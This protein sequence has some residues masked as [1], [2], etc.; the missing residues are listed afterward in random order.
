MEG[1]ERLRLQNRVRRAD[2]A[3]RPSLVKK[4]SDTR[5]HLMSCRHELRRSSQAGHQELSPEDAAKAVN[6]LLLAHNDYLQASAGRHALAERVTRTRGA[7]ADSIKG[8]TDNKDPKVLASLLSAMEQ[9][10]APGL[11]YDDHLSAR[12]MELLWSVGAQMTRHLRPEP[13]AAPDGFSFDGQPTLFSA[14]DRELQR[15]GESLPSDR[16]AK[17]YWELRRS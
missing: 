11:S 16:G 5:R 13:A 14:R 8:F 2:M 1:L 15:M 7:L 10:V 9:R 17:K 12:Q 6:L 4:A 3:V